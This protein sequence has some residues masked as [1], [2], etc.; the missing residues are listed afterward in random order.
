LATTS[1]IVN[2]RALSIVLTQESLL[3]PSNYTSDP[4]LSVVTRSVN[5][6]T[7]SALVSTALGRVEWVSTLEETPE[8]ISPVSAILSC[9]TVEIEGFGTEAV[10]TVKAVVK[11]V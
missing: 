1:N 10:K 9:R 2:H 5:R 3:H 11:E 4:S 6:Y 7:T 8:K